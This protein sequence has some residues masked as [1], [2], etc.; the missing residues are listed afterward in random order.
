M[1]SNVKRL[2]LGGAAL[3]LAMS[4]AHR[5]RGDE[6]KPESKEARA[7]RLFKEGDA[8]MEAKRTDLACRAFAQSQEIDPKLG[9]LLNLAFCHETLGLVATAYAEYNEAA[10][11]AAQRGQRD[12]E[13]FARQR[14]AQVAP[15][16]SRARFELPKNQEVAQLELDG[17]FVPRAR[18]SA[19]H[20][21][22]PG[23][24]LLKVSAPG[25]KTRA[26]PFKVG[27]NAAQETIVVAPLEED[28]PEQQL[29]PLT[30]ASTNRRRT[31]TFVVGGIAVVGLAAGTFLGVRTLQLRDAGQIHCRG[32][33]CDPQ[34]V[35]ALDDA[36]DFATFANIAFGV[37]LLASGV[38]TYLLVTAPARAQRTVARVAPL[39]G[40]R[41][42]GVSLVGAW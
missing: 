40:T 19:F 26:L 33:E 41:E 29:V 38:A 31:L 42:A 15:R 27:D 14:A 24:H 12:R 9:T 7:E 39:V 3:V 34:G 13:E 36:H 35:A 2:F 22:D 32:K 30:E 23:E 20:F 17:N 21:L 8:H 1:P 6:P 16:M 25:K 37:G 10:A 4:L 5:A 18:W 28:V 11:W